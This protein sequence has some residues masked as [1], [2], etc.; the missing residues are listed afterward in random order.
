MKSDKIDAR[1]LVLIW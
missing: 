1:V